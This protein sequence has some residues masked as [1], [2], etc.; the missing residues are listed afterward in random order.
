MDIGATASLCQLTTHLFVEPR[1][2][3]LARIVLHVVAIAGGNRSTT[4]RTDTQHIGIHPSCLGVLCS[5]HCPTL[6]V[7]TIGDDDDGLAHTF[8]LSKAVR[9]H[10]DGSSNISTLRGNHRWRDI[11]QEHLGTDIVAGDGQLDESIAGKDDKTYL[12]VGKVVHQILDH[13]LRTVQT[14]GS[15]ILGEHRITDVHAD[16]GLDTRTLLVADLGTHL[17]TGQH[18]DEQGQCSEQQ[19]ELDSGTQTGHVRHQ[20]AQQVTVA[21]LTQTLLLLAHHQETYQQYD[22]NDC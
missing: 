2:D 16:D 11:R 14:T 17:R 22:R 3:G 13:H 6:V 12:V 18:D 20:L 21:K 7:F 10:V 8:L 9:S 5:F 4:G 19:P 15:D 1:H